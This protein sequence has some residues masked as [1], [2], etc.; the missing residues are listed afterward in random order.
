MATLN[1]Q[2]HKVVAFCL[3]QHKVMFWSTVKIKTIKRE[4]QLHAL[5]DGKKI[6]I[7]EASVRR[8]LQLEDENGKTKT[9]QQNEIAS[10]KRRVK[11]LEQK[12]RLR[13][14]GLKRLHKVGMSRRVESSGDEKD[15]GE[16]ASKQERRINS[17]DADKDVTLN[18]KLLMKNMMLATPTTTISSQ[19][20]QGRGKGIMIEEPVKPKKKDVQIMLDEEAAKILQVEFDEEE[21]LAR[22]K[23]KSNVAFIEEWDNIQAKKSCLMQKRLIMN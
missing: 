21:R 20:S 16:D 10:S 17:I 19:Q 5:V 12:K 8:D 4:S 23:D 2:N 14:H 18:K 15:L 9:T 13:T 3:N 6:I 11:K 7:T 22:E 1:L